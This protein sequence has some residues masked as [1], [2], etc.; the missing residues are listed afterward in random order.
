MRRSLLTLAVLTAPVG[1]ADDVTADAGTATATGTTTTSTS[2]ATT[3]DEPTTST[4]TASS[5]EVSATAPTST[6]ETGSATD[7]TTTGVTAGTTQSTTDTTGT[8]GTTDTSG[9]TATTDTSDTTTG[10]PGEPVSAEAPA[11]LRALDGLISL[12][13]SRITAL[14]DG[15]ALAL[16]SGGLYAK[17]IVLAQGDPDEQVIASAFIAPVR[18]RFDGATGA[19]KEARLLAKLGQGAPWG[20]SVQTRDLAQAENGDLLVAGTW[21]GLVEFFPDSPDSKL[22]LAEMKLNGN[23]LDRAEEPFFYRMTPDGDVLWLIRGRTPAGLQTTW[24]NYGKGIVALPGDDVFIAGEYEKSGFVVADGTPGAKTMTGSQSS[25]FARLGAG[26]SPTWVY[27][28]T[29]RLPWVTLKGGADGA[30]YSLIPTNATIFADAGAPTMTMA[31]PDL[32]TAVLGRIDPAGGLEWTA[33]FATTNSSPVR[34]YELSA[35]G[36]VFVFGSVKGDLLVRDAGGLAMNTQTAEWEGW[37]AGLSATGEGLWIRTL[38]PAV[39]FAIPSLP[40]DDGVWLVARVAAPYELE[41]AGSTVPLPPLGYPDESKA[42]VLL[43]LGSTGEVTHAQVVGVNLPIDSLAW[44]SP[45][46]LAFLLVGGYWCDSA[47][48]YVVSDGGDGLTPLAL[49][50]DM[51]PL[52]DQRGYVAAVPRSP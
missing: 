42:T 14:P 48:P 12:A 50:C 51:E 21:S 46:Q 5:G 24:F 29:A 13:P 35:A 28:N 47:Q 7:T 6:S 23:N 34:G 18:A 40:D 49:Y 20:M 9:T 31:E 43:H 15:D 41:I 36:D 22:M 17:E 27:R 1:C 30:I 11:W 8:T 37:V 38:G 26:G 33:N 4:A 25:Y 39:E 32:M 52:D 10:D 16:I 3:A 19:L 44:S 2:S 45:D